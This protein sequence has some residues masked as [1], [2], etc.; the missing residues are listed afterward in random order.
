MITKPPDE[1]GGTVDA[2]RLNSCNSNA[3]L[4]R[5]G[6]EVNYT[7]VQWRREAD[8]L[9]GEFIRTGQRKHLTAFKIH[10]RAM[11]GRLWRL[12][13]TPAIGAQQ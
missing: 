2:A 3:R 5:F 8:R 9:L 6:P 13:S 1:A 4:F 10:C 7:P 12:L 11:G